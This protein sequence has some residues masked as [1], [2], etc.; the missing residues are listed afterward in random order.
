MEKE[1]SNNTGTIRRIKKNTFIAQAIITTMVLA[2]T[3]SLIYSIITLLASTITIG[4][5]MIMIKLVDKYFNKGE[6]KVALF[7]FMF[8]KFTIIAAIFYPVSRVSEAAVLFYILGLSV[9][10]FST[11]MEGFYQ[12]YRSFRNGT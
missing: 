1:I 7:S 9:L 6:G 4:G 12:I 2:F 10:V 11:M 8:A 5:F 3:K